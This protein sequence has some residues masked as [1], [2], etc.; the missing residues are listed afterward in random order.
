MACARFCCRSVLMEACRDDRIGGEC[1]ARGSRPISQ[2]GRQSVN[3]SISQSINQSIIQ[4]ISQSVNQSMAQSCSFR[5]QQATR[6]RTSCLVSRRRM[7]RVFLKRRSRGTY[8]A[9]PYFSRSW[10]LGCRGWGGGLG[11]PSLFGDGRAGGA[12]V[13]GSGR[14]GR[15]GGNGKG[16]G[17]AAVDPALRCH[18]T[19]VHHT[20]TRPTA[21]VTE[22]SPSRPPD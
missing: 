20:K 21:R 5:N 15:R 19:A 2:S 4:S 9:L 22:I 13:V 6:Q 11:V 7:A 17:D 16:G 8:L 18:H 1:T 10:F 14:A 3:Q 12:S